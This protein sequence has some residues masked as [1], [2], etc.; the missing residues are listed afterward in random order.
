M[1]RRAALLLAATTLFLAVAAGGLASYLYRA[2]HRAVDDLLTRRLEA[3][4]TTA[5]RLVAGAADGDRALADV[6]SAN[7]LDGA[8][9]IDEQLRIVT[10]AQG[11]AGRQAN[12]LRLDPDRA[13]A[14]LGGRDSVAWAFDVEGTRFLGG[15]FPVH[16]DGRK[17]ALA[18]EAGETFE[19]PSRRLD[20]AAIAAF[21]VGGALAVLALVALALAARAARREREAYGRAE[22]AGLASR[23]AAMV[24]H[25]VRNPLGIIRGGAELLRERAG[26]EGDRELLDD[27]LG[28]VR[29]LNT[30]TEEF[31]ELGRDGALSL[32]PVAIGSLAREVCEGVALRFRDHPLEIVAAGDA[33]ALADESK[34]RQALLNL[35]L[36]A[37][38]ASD[39]KGAVRVETVADAGGVRI[40]VTDTGPGVPS[41]LRAHL[42]EPF[43]TGKSGGTGLGLA[44]ARK[45][46][47]RHGGRLSYV[48]TVRGARFDAWMPAA[49]PSAR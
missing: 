35:T 28:E 9:V 48:S 1:G 49:P 45:I 22:R 33:T 15:Y 30:L 42:F 25:E 8:Y 12:L 36:N 11:R 5:A 47:E 16:H 6:A 41:E 37:A 17:L 38:Q 24:A 39:G 4:G 46:L 7:Q 34:L 32:T 10:D 27:I 14:A 29:R 31:L 43:V 26:D 3:V 13:H 18:I 2:A 20:A 23:M 40:T 44:V 21:T 19:A